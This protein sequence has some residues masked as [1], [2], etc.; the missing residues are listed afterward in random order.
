VRAFARRRP[1]AIRRPRRGRNRRTPFVEN[2]RLAARELVRARRALAGGRADEAERLAIRALVAAPGELSGYRVLGKALAAQ[3][4]AELAASCRRGELPDVVLLAHVDPAPAPVGPPE[5][6]VRIVL[7][8]GERI[9]VRRPDGM[10]PHVAPVFPK[11]GIVAAATY[12]DRVAD[13][14]V[15]QDA[16]DTV[17]FDRGGRILDAHTLG[18]ARLVAHLAAGHEPV[19]LGRR[20]IVLGARGSGN[21]YHWLTD[22]L[23]KLELCRLAGIEPGPDDR[24]VL[25][26]RRSAFQIDTLAMYGIDESQVHFATRHSPYVRADELVVP[27]LKNAMGT[28]MGAWL[29]AALARLML[30]TG[31][32]LPGTRRLFVSRDPARSQGREVANIVEVGEWFAA[33]GFEVVFPE[34]L[35]VVEQ[36]R[37]FASAGTVAAPHGAGLAN[38]VF[39]APGT[40]V[41]EFYGAHLA[42][43]YW[44]ISAL[45]GLDY[46]ACCCLDETSPEDERARTRP[47]AARRA[48]GFSIDLAAA[49]AAL[50][51]S[52]FG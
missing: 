42:P 30:G 15:W 24:V 43:C 13:G 22:V 27:R 51:R 11:R 46:H 41:V 31:E 5:P 14:R 48:A 17:V 34:T 21:Y 35:S 20:A 9:D 32:R 23:P 16:H 37:L 10:T 50:E 26:F 7:G 47:L 25:P 36:A 3:G 38:I 1:A 2:R 4:R 18:N 28:T 6:P 49:A 19:A 39:C 44:A 33:R 12:V 45:T 29:P 8:G 52:G 40:R